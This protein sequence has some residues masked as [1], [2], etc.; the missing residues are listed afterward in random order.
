MENVDFSD[1]RD[2]QLDTFTALLSSM[3]RL[4]SYF[5]SDIHLYADIEEF[6][7]ELHT[8]DWCGRHERIKP[9][10]MHKCAILSQHGDEI[11]TRD[12]ERWMTQKHASTFNETLVLLRG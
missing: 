1:A 9:M 6:G 7:V 5:T 12:R 11:F 3:A 10:K 2:R 8:R 4:F